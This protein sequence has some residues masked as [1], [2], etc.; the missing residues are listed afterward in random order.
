[1]PPNA[2]QIQVATDAL[3]TEAD[4]WDAQAGQLGTIQSK[5]S[6]LTFSRLE[7]GIFQV[8]VSVNDDLVNHV[9]ARCGEG[10]AQMTSIASTLRSVADTY[11]AEERSNEHSFRNL[12]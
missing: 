7:A 10:K 8:L 2:Q 4:I 11:D 1:V 12:Y 5:V 6:G 9:T 3:R